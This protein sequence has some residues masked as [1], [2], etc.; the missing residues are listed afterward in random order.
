MFKKALLI[1]AI[2]TTS[3][4]A[5]DAN[6]TKEVIKK[7]PKEVQQRVKFSKNFCSAVEEAKKQMRPIFFLV[8]SHKCKYCVIFENSVLKDE[9]VIKALNSGFVS[10]E[11]FVDDGDYIP[12]EFRKP[13]TPALW[14]LYPNGDSMFQPIM[15]AL[16]KE[17]FLKALTT[18]NEAFLEA[19]MGG[20]N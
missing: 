4:I 14:F 5:G 16:D 3:L 20:K 9:V 12:R 17:N 6:S 15:G 8:T 19:T 18:V 2:V 7:A 11:V 1:V 10:L 13:G